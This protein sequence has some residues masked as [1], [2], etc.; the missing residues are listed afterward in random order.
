MY[1]QGSEVAALEEI[2]KL[3]ICNVLKL[4]THVDM[5]SLAYAMERQHRPINVAIAYHQ[6]H[7][8]KLHTIAAFDSLIPL[9][10]LQWLLNTQAKEYLKFASRFAR[11]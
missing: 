2:W 8:K 4:C 10:I 11:T 5:A 3:I 1:M 7:H 6:G 9:L